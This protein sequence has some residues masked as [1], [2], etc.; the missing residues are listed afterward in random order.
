MCARVTFR[1]AG[2]CGAVLLVV[3]A[4]CTARESKSD[5]GDAIRRGDELV[6]QKRYAEAAGVYRIAASS[7]VRNGQVRKKLANA[8]VLAGRWTDASGEAVRA[9]DLLPGD[10]DAQLLAASFMLGQQRFVDV[11]ARMSAL[12]EQSPDNF[13]ALILWGNAKARLPNTTFALSKL[14]DVMN[15]KAA[16]DATRGALRKPVA[17]LDD[18]A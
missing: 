12:L 18:N 4:G 5:T 2:L 1:K 6:G 11:L 7:D 16:F 3:V 10:I 15:D 14:A 17:A 13:K 8:L 9:A